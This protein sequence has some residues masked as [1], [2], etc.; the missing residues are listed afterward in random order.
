MTLSF[1]K[2]L[3]QQLRDSPP[4]QKGLRTRLRLKIAAAKVLERDGYHA[5][6]VADISAAAKLAEG[7]FYVYFSDK[8][9]VA[10][11]VLRELLE[12][13]LGL[14]IEASEEH[15]PFASIRVA[16]RRWIAVCRA[17]A[18]LMRCILQLGDEDPNLAQLAQRTNRA[19]FERIAQSSAKRRGST[20]GAAAAVLAAYLLG[21]M[22]DELARKLIIYPD[23]RF[24]ELLAD[25]KADDEAVADAASVVWLRVFYPEARPPKNLPS[26]ATALADWI[27][28]RG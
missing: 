28:M 23:P 15:D 20:R 18:G 1:I 16:N 13:F 10:L 24:L 2:H 25:L 5:L 6:R 14:D 21:G 22:M 4:K 7:S 17:N 9:D 19:W 26:A 11:T 8:T 27:G 3:E 12:E